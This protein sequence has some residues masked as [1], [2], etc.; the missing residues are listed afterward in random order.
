MEGIMERKME[1]R[2]KKYN[3]HSYVYYV[4]L[5]YNPNESTHVVDAINGSWTYDCQ[6]QISSFRYLIAFWDNYD[7]KK[8]NYLA[9]SPSPQLTNLSIFLKYAEVR[10]YVFEEFS[11]SY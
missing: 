5:I 7:F 6:E 4:E 8:S 10:W 9:L 3:D 11:H 2:T 1:R